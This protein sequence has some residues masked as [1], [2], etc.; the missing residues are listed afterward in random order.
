MKVRSG[1]YP[2][3]EAGYSMAWWAAFLAF[4]LVPLMSLA[5]DITRLLHVRTDLQAAIDAACEAA[6][7][8]PDLGAFRETGVQSINEGLAGAYAAYAFRASV[9]EADLVQYDPALTMLSTIG[10]SEVAC[11]AQAVVRSLIP[12]G[13]RLNVAVAARAKMRFIQR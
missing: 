2:L 11:G 8:A 5:V 1:P 7:L 6:A 4:V 12:F 9:V 13:L 10:P 3:D